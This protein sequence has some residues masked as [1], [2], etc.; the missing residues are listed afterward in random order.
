MAQANIYKCKPAG[1]VILMTIVLIGIMLFALVYI[2]LNSPRLLSSL[3]VAGVVV[4]VIGVAFAGTPRSVV[5]DDD[6]VGIRL[7]LRGTFIPM[8]TIVGLRRVS[9]REVFL[10]GMHHGVGGFFSYS[11]Y[12]KNRNLGSFKMYVRNT[13]EMV[14]IDCGDRGVVVSAE[15]GDKLIEDILSRKRSN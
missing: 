4:V 11:G 1:E 6:G 3:L 14:F 15:S 7:T 13:S 5:V 8:D 10:G 2:L 9:K 12:A